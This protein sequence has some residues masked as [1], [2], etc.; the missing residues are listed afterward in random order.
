[1]KLLI[2]TNHFFPETFRANDIAFGLAARGHDVSVLTGIPDY[3]EGKYHEGYGLFRR[4]T[5]TLRGVRIYR[6][7][8]IP[9]GRGGKWRLALNYASS[10]VFMTVRALW[11][12]LFHHYDAVLVHE[13]SPVMVGTPARLLSRMQG[14]PMYFW[15]LDLWPESLR[16]AGG[17]SSPAILGFFER[18][19]R[20]YY[21]AS[22]KILISSQGFRESI[23]RMGDFSWKTVYFPNWADNALVPPTLSTP[24]PVSP[25]GSSAAE[26]IFAAGLIPRGFVVMFAGN[27]GEAQDFESIAQAALILKSAAREQGAEKEI[28]LVIVGDGRKM[29][30]LKEFIAAHD[31][32]DTVH[33]LGRHPVETMPSFFA[34]A[35]VMLVSLKDELIFGLTLP[36]KIQAYM[37]AGKPLIAMMNGEGARV[38]DEA[39][40]GRHVRAGDAEAL[41]RAILALSCESGPAFSEMGRNAREYCLRH[42]SFASAMQILENLLSRNPVLPAD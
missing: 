29:P 31:L 28:H 21:S 25:R 2:V 6:S 36:A 35:D 7:F 37:A 16:A 22:E 33:L 42:F 1:M 26:D 10:L 4:R 9:R 8:L 20:R 13:T 23:C 34:R 24:P 27:V 30:W 32:S 14:I 12:A 19:T 41:A 38:I 3:P 15:V 5:E 17:I 11:L 40:C 18:L 39:R